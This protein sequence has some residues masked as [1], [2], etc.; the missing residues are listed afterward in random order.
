MFSCKVSKSEL[1]EIFERFLHVNDKPR[2]E[3]YYINNYTLLVAVILSAQ[4]TDVGVNKATKDLFNI[5]KTPVDMLNL[6]EDNLKKHIKTIGLYNSKASNIIRTSRILIN[7]FNGEIPNKLEDL[8]TLPGVGR[9]TANVILA[10]AFNYNTIA[11]D[12]HVFRVSNRIGIASADNVYDTEMQLLSNIPEKWIKNAH[13]WLILHGRYV[14]KAR[15]PMCS[16]CIIKDLCHYYKKNIKNYE[17]EN[18]KT[19]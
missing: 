8:C 15:N 3:L 7:E 5:V 18:I 1:N 12:T 2:S 19:T 6:G 17:E 10:V 9:K 13:H 16:D 14:C 11:V 4:S